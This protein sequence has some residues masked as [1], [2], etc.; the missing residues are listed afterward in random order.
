MVLD[1]IRHQGFHE[2]NFA[3][4]SG[5]L[6]VVDAVTST[7][8]VTDAS[9]QQ[10][11]RSG[12][13]QPNA[14]I[15]RTPQSSVVGTASGSVLVNSPVASFTLDRLT[16]SVNVLFMLAVIDCSKV[17]RAVIAPTSQPSM[18]AHGMLHRVPVGVTSSQWL[19]SLG[20]DYSETSALLS[21]GKHR[22]CTVG[23]CGCG[24]NIN[25]SRPA[26][27][28]VTLAMLMVTT[29]WQWEMLPALNAEGRGCTAWF[30]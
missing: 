14:A 15:S 3:I 12:Q 30:C 20:S 24:L 4:A 5:G 25:L 9:R 18:Q 2:L 17:Q 26:V 13:H 21:A 1:G 22:L 7:E 11:E 16:Y 10:H 29:F 8:F 6:D 23:F 28:T 19:P 27:E